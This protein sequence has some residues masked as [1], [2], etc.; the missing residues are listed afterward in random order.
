MRDDTCYIYLLR[1]PI[2]NEVKYI[3]KTNNL[4]VRLKAHLN[5]ARFKNTHKFN[6]I[7]K[8]RNKNLKPTL[9][10][11]EKC[12][13]NNWKEREK[14]WIK[15]YLDA[16]TKLTNKTDGGDGLTFGNQTSFKKGEGG[17]EVEGY[18]KEGKL[19]HKFQTAAEASNFFNLNRSTITACA[20]GYNKTVKGLAW[21]Y[22]NDL[23]GIN[24]KELLKI[25]K[26]RFTKKENKENK[27]QFIK[28]CISHRAKILKCTF[29][30]TTKIFENQTKCANYIGVT[31]S[32]ISYALRNNTVI[33]NKFKIDIYE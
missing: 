12:S 20:L 15:Y 9:E 19:I 16:G 29:N 8:L 6:W 33:K 22:K 7:K 3:G 5:P 21:F 11:I 17:K 28:G 31:Q 27:G 32:A 4:K 10:I 1:D 2:D 14:Y 26:D 25:L 13:I 18:N 23:V 24:K 30:D